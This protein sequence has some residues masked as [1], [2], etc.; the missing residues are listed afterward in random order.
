MRRKHE[1]EKRVNEIRKPN[2]LQGLFM[3]NPSLAK[4]H[5]GSGSFAL[6]ILD[7]GDEDEQYQRV[8]RQAVGGTVRFSS[9]TI[10]RRRELGPE[11]GDQAQ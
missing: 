8:G 3:P 6:A 5:P 2:G 10:F 7:Q 11:T 4:D 9:G 1:E